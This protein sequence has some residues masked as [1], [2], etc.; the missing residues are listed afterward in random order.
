ML[1]TEKF[2]RRLSEEW[3]IPFCSTR[4]LSSYEF[5]AKALE[6]LSSTDA[7]D[8]MLAVDS[9]FVCHKEGTFSADCS[10]AKEQ[11]F[12][13]G[14]RNSIPRKIYLWLEPIITIAGLARLRRDFGWPGHR[15]GM[16]S[17]T[18]AFDL[19]GYNEDQET[20]LLVCEVKKT[21]REVDKL[22]EL[23]E[24]HMATPREAESDFKGAERNAIK[25]VLGLRQSTATTFWALGPNRYGHIFNI[26][27]SSTDIVS[28]RAVDESALFFSN[29]EQF[30]ET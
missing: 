2:V 20:E 29:A 26:L 8:F 13:H 19:V 23:M 30:Q 10:K 5:D 16:Q 6:K 15:L 27:H 4:G 25:K 12:H 22:V 21:E 24:K 17:R 18:W 14:P 7:C 9:G 1:A 3:L 28:L 11:I